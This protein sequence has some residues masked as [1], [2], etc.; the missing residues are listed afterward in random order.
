VLGIDGFNIYNIRKSKTKEEP[1]DSGAN[2]NGG[3]S[4]G[5]SSFIAEFLTKKLIGDKRKSRTI[6]SIRGI[7]KVTGNNLAIEIVFEEKN[8]TKGL[9]Y[10][11]I[12][13]DNQS[14]IIAKINFLKVGLLSSILITLTSVL[15]KHG[16]AA[17][18][19]AQWQRH[20]VR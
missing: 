20:H 3:Q 14:E 13:A 2:G 4:K 12:N 11:C 1:R 15:E 16:E 19:E 8:S 10:E 5:K 18:L 9:V 6:N 7:R 17:L